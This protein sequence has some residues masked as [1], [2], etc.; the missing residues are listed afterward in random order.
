MLIV[1]DSQTQR[2][3]GGVPAIKAVIYHGGL[4]MMMKNP[5]AQ[6]L[7]CVLFWFKRVL[8]DSNIVLRIF[9]LLIEIRRK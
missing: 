1:I 5:I 7:G 8:L 4:E 6:H 9:Y 2:T 3:V